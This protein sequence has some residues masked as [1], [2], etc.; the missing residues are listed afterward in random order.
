MAMFK[1]GSDVWDAYKPTQQR[2]LSSSKIAGKERLV[3][4]LWFHRVVIARMEIGLR[5]GASMDVFD[6][7]RHGPYV[8]AARTVENAHSIDLVQKYSAYYNPLTWLKLYFIRR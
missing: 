7:F 2:K 5:L 6:C 3:N 8:Q 4:E 1:M